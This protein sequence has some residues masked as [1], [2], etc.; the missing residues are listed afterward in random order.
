MLVIRDKTTKKYINCFQT[1]ADA[2][3]LE[4]NAGL[5][6]VII[7]NT[8]CVEV[9]KEEYAAAKAEYF[10]D[11]PPAEKVKEV[12]TCPTCSA[13]IIKETGELSAVVDK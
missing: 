10:T 3:T 1:N 2:K 6:G 11:N 8:E 5:L 12:I 7:D 9:S 13:K 4:Y